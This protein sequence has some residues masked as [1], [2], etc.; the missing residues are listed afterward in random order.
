M[1]RSPRI[2]FPE[3]RKPGLPRRIAVVGEGP[4]TPYPPEQVAQL[5]LDLGLALGAAGYPVS[6][7]RQSLRCIAR[8]YEAN[9]QVT[10]LPSAIFVKVEGAEAA[11]VDLTSAGGTRL[12]LDQAGA[13]IRV[14]QQAESAEI[15]PLD[16]IAAVRAIWRQEPRF[17][18]ATRALGYGLLAMGLSVTLGL[19]MVAALWCLGIGFAAGLAKLL[20]ER[21]TAVQPLIPAFAAFVVGLLTFGLLDH[22]VLHGSVLLIVPP[23]V[24][25]FPGGTL[26]TAVVELSNGDMVSG[27]S[28]LVWGAGQLAVLIFGLAA[29]A[30]VSGI[31]EQQAFA[32]L[33]TTAQPWWTGIIGV[34]IYGVGVYLTFAGA[35]HSLPWLYLMLAVAYA[36]QRIGAQEY[37]AY[38]STY[39]SAA[40]VLLLAIALETREGAPP[41]IVSFLPAFWLLIPGSLGLIGLG[42]LVSRDEHAALSDLVETTFTIIAVSLGLLTGILVGVAL[43]LGS[44]RNYQPD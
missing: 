29:G 12:R 35:R 13:V 22:G 1:V 6:L 30:Q 43:G 21:Y 37:S 39:L 3:A 11:V 19:G 2:R 31:D 9:V 33:V 20:G 44:M 28:R 16:A 34:G 7:A 41:A 18:T 8:A 40:A 26:T 27:T 10:V 14:S 5:I 25:F 15:A 42:H 24:G 17:S 36:I 23:L 4:A 32:S 38:I